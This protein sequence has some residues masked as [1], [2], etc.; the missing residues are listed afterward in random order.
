MTTPSTFA[1]CPHDTAK[2]F[3][4]WAFFNTLVNKS[5]ELRSRFCPCLNFAEFTKT[6]ESEELLWAYFNPADYIKA[7]ARF[8]YDAIARPVN[9]ADIARVVGLAAST[10]TD[11]EGLTGKRLAAVNGYLFF[12]ARKVLADTGVTFEH[13]PAKSYADVMSL[14]ENGQADYGVTYNEHFDVLVPGTKSRF[15]EVRSFEMGLSHVV[16]VHP[17]MPADARGRLT[18]LLLGTGANAE[19]KRILDTLGFEGFEE[20]PSAPFEALAS[21]LAG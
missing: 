19:R 13:V 1:V 3:D 2:G 11:S 6:L 20:A 17:S 12:V 9:R 8:G 7:R 18:E 15:R 16:A 5:V 10:A 4:K 21:I 14:V